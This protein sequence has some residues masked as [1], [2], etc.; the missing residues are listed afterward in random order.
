M[1]DEESGSEEKSGEEETVEV[2]KK[3][4]VIETCELKEGEFYPDDW[5]LSHKEDTPI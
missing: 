2:V 5:I 1:S 4:P 3:V